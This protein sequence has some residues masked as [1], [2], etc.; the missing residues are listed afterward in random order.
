MNVLY[1]KYEDVGN[2]TTDNKMWEQSQDKK[3]KGAYRTMD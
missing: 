2:A 1:S 3:A